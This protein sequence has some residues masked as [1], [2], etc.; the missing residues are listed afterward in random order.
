M[1]GR[2]KFFSSGLLVVALAS[3]PAAAQATSE[4]STAELAR[5]VEQLESLVERLTARLAELEG[6][7]PAA[8]PPVAE[9]KPAVIASDRTIGG[10]EARLLP[11][12]SVAGGS[13]GLAK[14][15]VSTHGFIN[16]EYLDSGDDGA[17][18]GVSHFDL[19]HANVFFGARLRD[20]LAAHLEIEYE[21]AGDVVEIDQAYV[22]W[23][24]N[25]GLSLEAGRFYTPFGIERFTWYAPTNELVSRPSAFRDIVPGNFYATGLRASGV[26]D[27]ADG[28]PQVTYEVAVTDGLGA[29]AVTD[30]RGARQTR[31]NNSSRALSGRVSFVGYPW[32]EAGVSYH[33]QT[34]D[35][36]SQLGLDF[37][38]VDFSGRYRGFE[39]RG[40]WL[41]SVAERRVAGAFASDLEKDGWYGQLAYRFDFERD[42]FPSLS[43][44]TRY[45]DVDLD[46]SR[47]GNDDRTFWSV[48]FNAALYEHFRVKLE[49]QFA[50][51]KGAARDNDTL[52][53]QVVV[54]F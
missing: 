13:Y 31:D 2:G 39:L 33:T 32:W 5:R 45:D 43:L 34:Y 1:F 53:G 41:E 35:D 46:R 40:E 18:G 15:G 12:R 16:L 51:E 52:L 8:A 4:P 28:Q 36:A 27:G 38:G 54:D 50:D 10:E 37:L 26:F 49:Y 19:H 48:G 44:V 14:S 9:A 30:P 47:V 22:S 42:F 23:Q 11:S 20:N 7:A 21:H 17:R 25:E 24:V 6:A 3:S 29:S